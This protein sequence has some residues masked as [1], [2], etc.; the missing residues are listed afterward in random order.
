[1]LYQHSSLIYRS[2]EELKEL[3]EELHSEAEQARKVPDHP[4]PDFKINYVHIQTLTNEIEQINKVIALREG[5][6][7]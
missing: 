4:P 6:V 7:F 2:T 1:M 5:L 3:V